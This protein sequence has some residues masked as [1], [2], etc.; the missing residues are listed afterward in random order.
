[1]KLLQS[2]GGAVSFQGGIILTR[3]LFD[4]SKSAGERL[5]F[6]YSSKHILMKTPITYYGGKQRMLKHIL[7]LIPKHE[8]Y[9]EPFCGGAAVFFAKD[10]S[11]IEVIND[12]NRMVI[13][14]Y[15]HLQVHFEELQN[16]IQST[17]LSR[18]CHQDAWVMYNF[19]HLFSDLEL[20]W[21]FWVLTQQGIFGKIS[22]TWGFSAATPKTEKTLNNKRESFLEAYKQRLAVVQIECNDALKVIKS[23]DRETSFFYIDPPYFN[24]EMGHYK[25]YSKQ[26]FTNLLELLSTIKGKF[27][28]SS[29]PSDVLADFTKQFG[30][31]TVE[32]EQSVAV[33]NKGKRKVE[34]L[35]MN[36]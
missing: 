30:W 35:T 11:N 18:S 31:K 21:A 36:Y 2:S 34:V 5:S 16:R 14:F 25:G 17:L 32:I 27:L 7:P 24:S 23:R 8:L 22:E 4:E 15:T 13:N 20:A 26:D 1:M 9:C 29:Y 3:I 12:M 19:Q 33:S 28:L 10:K 6:I